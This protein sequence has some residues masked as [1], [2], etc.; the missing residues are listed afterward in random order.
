[1]KARVPSV[2]RDMR[3]QDLPAV[4]AL[5]QRT[6][7][8]TAWSE[9]TWWA[10]LASRPRRAYL[11]HEGVS[12]GADIAGYAGVSIS[13]DHADVM[14][15]TVDPGRRGAGIGALLLLGLHQQAVARGA[16]QVLLEV[17]ADNESAQ[18]LYLRNGYQAISRRRAY[19]QPEGVDAIVMRNDLAQRPD[20]GAASDATCG[21]DHDEAVT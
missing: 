18:R 10:E 4:I 21:P 8:Q 1:M 16:R 9:T 17:R 20:Q 15:I 6:Y 3:W 19:Y 13:G 11:V 5:E 12:S 7:P 2:L 14:T